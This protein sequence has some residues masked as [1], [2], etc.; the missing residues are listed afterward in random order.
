MIDHATLRELLPQGHPMMLVDRIVSI[1]PGV[2]I[3]GVKAITGGEPCY[4][5]IARGC[6]Q[7]RFAY[8]VS[9][10]LESFGQTAAVLWLAGAG[11]SSVAAD[12]VMMLVAVR[13]ARIEGRAFPGDV[14]RHV[15][16]VD[17]V[18]GDSVLV[19]G[20]T[21][22]GDARVVTIGSM[23]AVLRPRAAVLGRA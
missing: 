1:D 15:A 21:F 19:S 20:E 17:Q 22:V 14:L 9:L 8:P 10:L 12:S 7:D 11:S 16:R 3:V 6:G 13:D 4:R 5:D 2:S 18:V 23:M